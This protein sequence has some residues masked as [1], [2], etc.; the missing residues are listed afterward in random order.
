MDLKRDSLT[1]EP[2]EVVCFI[3]P[4]LDHLWDLRSCVYMCMLFGSRLL[5][6]SI[7]LGVKRLELQVVFRELSSFVLV[8][9]KSL[10]CF[11]R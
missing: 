1:N 10:I 6:C 8:G 4:S 7:E 3:Y 9:V 2:L 5:V 11:G